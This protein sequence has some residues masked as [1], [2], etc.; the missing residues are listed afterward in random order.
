MDIAID[1]RMLKYAHIYIYG[2]MYTNVS[3]PA[4]FFFFFF[5]PKSSR[6]DFT[7]NLDAFMLVRV[8]P[9]T[10]QNVNVGTIWDLI[11][12]RHCAEKLKALGAEASR[13]NVRTH[14]E[15]ASP[16]EPSGLLSL[17][18]SLSNL[19]T[20]T[21]YLRGLQ[22]HLSAL[23][24]IFGVH[25]CNAVCGSYAQDLVDL[26]L[27][28]GSDAI[29]RSST[30]PLMSADYAA[31]SSERARQDDAMPELAA[32][33]VET[34]E[35]P[36][37]WKEQPDLIYIYTLR[38]IAA[39]VNPLFAEALNTVLDPA[40]GLMSADC[41]EELKLERAA[42]KSHGR[43][44]GK[45]AEDHRYARFP[46]AAMNIDVVRL[47]AEASTAHAAQQFIGVVGSEFGGLS[48]LKCLADSDPVEK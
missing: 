1:I 3:D 44:A 46:K 43:M 36:E 2:Y 34:H 29:R 37:G 24:L 30:M 8:D 7:N 26:D 25:D 35:S 21:N 18:L 31:P 15:Y 17:S 27:S 5:S 48:H 38:L 14:R 33:F 23:I 19:H 12:Q 28:L 32:L 22:P 42:I 4:F 20:Y 45:L 11:V 39:V 16:Y 40:R 6:F 41:L 10:G 13:I 9:S 47:L